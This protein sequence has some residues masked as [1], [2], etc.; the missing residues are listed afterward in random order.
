MEKIKEQCE[1]MLEDKMKRTQ[2][3]KGGEKDWKK[4]TKNWKS[5]RKTEEIWQTR[6]EAEKTES[7]R[8]KGKL[9][10]EDWICLAS[11]FSKH[12]LTI[13]CCC[14]HLRLPSQ[15]FTLGISQ[16]PSALPEIIAGEGSRFW[17]IRS[18]F[19]LFLSHVHLAYYTLWPPFLTFILCLVVVTDFIKEKK[20]QLLLWRACCTCSLLISGLQWV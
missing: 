8:S 3:C 2:T 16:V 17:A 18:S 5:K 15:T 14:R 7:S 12:S 9:T 13:L 20:L 1:E 10:E 11:F 6:E 4:K 19:H